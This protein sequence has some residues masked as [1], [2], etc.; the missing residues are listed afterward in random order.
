[1]VSRISEILGISGPSKDSVRAC[2]AGP[3]CVDTLRSVLL[4]EIVLG[5]KIDPIDK[6]V[7]LVSDMAMV[8]PPHLAVKIRGPSRARLKYAR[9]HTPLCSSRADQV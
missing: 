1:M 8:P 9:G 7:L 6:G 2:A 5:T 4:A 3:F